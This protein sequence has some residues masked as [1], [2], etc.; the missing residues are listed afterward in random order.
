MSLDETAVPRHDAVTTMVPLV[1][2]AWQD[3]ICAFL[4]NAYTFTGCTWIDL[5]NLGGLSGFAGP[6]AGK[7]V[8]GGA[9]GNIT[10]PNVAMLVH[11]ACA[12]NR[13]Q[14]AGK[15]YLMG[16]NES[17]VD[18]GGMLASTAI[19]FWNS[20]WNA[21][22]TA[23]SGLSFLG[24]ETTAWRVVHVVGHESDPP[25]RP[26]AWNSTDVDNCIVDPKCATQR[27]RLRR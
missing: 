13:Q 26:N 9:G 25:H 12:H 20:K 8:N 11:L 5:D 2:G 16:L 6:V 18:N 7:P 4:N 15:K 3:N 10:T 27:R 22:R 21:L 23:L 24:I 14:R 1:V 17:D 19:T